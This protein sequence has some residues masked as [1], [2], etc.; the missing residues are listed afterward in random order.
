ML[1]NDCY[2]MRRPV[3]RDFQISMTCRDSLAPALGRQRKRA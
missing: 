1:L 2:D 3:K